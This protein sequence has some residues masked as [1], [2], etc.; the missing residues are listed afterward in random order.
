MVKSNNSAVGVKFQQ[1]HVICKHVH[2][3]HN[4]R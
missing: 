1:S 4:D 3:L 2:T